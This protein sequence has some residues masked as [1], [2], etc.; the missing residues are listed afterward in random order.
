MWHK[1]WLFVTLLDQ[2]ELVFDCRKLDLQ[3]EV[4]NMSVEIKHLIALVGSLGGK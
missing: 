4:P 3:G 2:G 1:P